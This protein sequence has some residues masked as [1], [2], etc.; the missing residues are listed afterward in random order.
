MANTPLGFT[1]N[2]HI[3]LQN[4]NTHLYTQQRGGGRERENPKPIT[5]LILSYLVGSYSIH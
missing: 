1:H 3:P 4:L 2:L 5:P